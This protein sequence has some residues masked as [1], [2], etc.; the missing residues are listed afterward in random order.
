M[1]S[2]KLFGEKRFSMKMQKLLLSTTQQPKRVGQIVP[3]P[4]LIFNKII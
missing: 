4:Y 3:S 2:L 1:L